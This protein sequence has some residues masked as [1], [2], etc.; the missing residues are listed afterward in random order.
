MFA[1]KDD[2]SEDFDFSNRPAGGGGLDAI[3]ARD[4]A[5]DALQ[6]S[7]V[8]AFECSQYYDARCDLQDA[9]LF[10]APKRGGQTEK[11]PKTEEAPAVVETA[12]PE[13][14]QILY[15]C[16][17]K[18]ECAT[19]NE[20]VQMGHVAVA[21]LSACKSAPQPSVL[22]Y[23]PRTRQQYA[24]IAASNF[25]AM[26]G[27]IKL[28]N[29]AREFCLS[30]DAPA[31]QEQSV[32]ATLVMHLLALQVAQTRKAVQI[33]L[34][35]A[36]STRV[37]KQG[38]RAHVRVMGE[39][40]GGVTKLEHS[41]DAPRV[42][43]VALTDDDDSEQPSW[44]PHLLGCSRAQQVVVAL[45]TSQ[46]CAA[47][48]LNVL[49]V[50]RPRANTSATTQEESAPSISTEQSVEQPQQPRQPQP[51]KPQ[52]KQPTQQPQ[53]QPTQQP[54][55]QPKQ[56]E[57][58]QVAPTPSTVDTPVNALTVQRSNGQ[59]QEIMDKLS[60]LSAQV[61]KFNVLDINAQW[62]KQMQEMNAQWIH[63]N[64]ANSSKN[65]NNSANDSVSREE[66]ER[67]QQQAREK[68][69][70]LKTQAR[71]AAQQMYNDGK[72]AGRNE[73]ARELAMM[74]DQLRAL[75]DAVRSSCSSADAD[76][77]FRQTKQSLSPF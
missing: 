43:K 26:P 33:Q 73:A 27:M 42:E 28:T 16:A 72:E 35:P 3:F 31:E 55:K 9:L 46:G 37:V 21:I 22:L 34:T 49:K 76:A 10:R 38:D 41:K 63:A 44:L 77:I 65:D 54:Q 45:P 30:F 15:A 67:M 24:H 60:A 57:Q 29:D 1:P 20:T 71:E 5:R 68:M 6:D 51:Q 56:Q 25:K 61:A 4:S 75:A 39:V 70:R 47:T 32:F 7:E 59:H 62:M 14:P 18:C 11:P 36:T 12:L 19:R 8:S 40:S 2:L 53:Q 58:Q 50:G 23:H 74:R 52:Q 69:Q 64:S 66:H 48:W 13:S 17:A